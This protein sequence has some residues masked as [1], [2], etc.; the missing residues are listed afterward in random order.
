[1]FLM[2]NSSWKNPI[3]FQAEGLDIVKP[4][5]KNMMRGMLYSYFMP[6]LSKNKAVFDKSRRLVRL[7]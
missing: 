7:Y 6:E 2:V 1:M 4:R 3:E 5:I